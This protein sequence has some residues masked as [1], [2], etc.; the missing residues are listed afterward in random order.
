[1]TLGLVFL[2]IVI[3]SFGIM[4]IVYI[5]LLSKDAR[6]ILKDNH[7]TLE[8]CNNM[9]KSLESVSRDTGAVTVFEHNLSMQEK[10][11][12]EVGERNATIELRK[13]FDRLKASPGDSTYAHNIRNAIY[14]IQD[15]NQLAILRKNKTASATAEN[16]T[17]WL[18]IIVTILTIV[19]FTFI[20]N[21]PGIISA[22]LQALSE[23][24][25]A[26]AGKN[27]SKRI[28][29][30]QSDEFGELAGAFNTMAEKLDEYEHSSLSQILFEKTRIETIINQ[31]KDGIIGFDEKGHVLFMN[32]VAE[33]LFGLKEAEITGQYNADIAIRNDLMRTL[34]QDRE[35]KE[36]KIY[37]DGKE[38]FFIKDPITVN[39]GE[40]L[41]GEV[42]VLRNIT[43]F[44]ELDEA[45]TNFIATVS[46]ELK[47]PMSSI[48]MS[49][50]LLN[51]TR[52]GDMNKEQQEL[53]KS[54]DDDIDRLLKI[55]GELLNMAQVE[56]GNIQLKLQQTTP[57]QVVEVAQLAVATQ[58]AQ[59]NLQLQ[60]F[61]QNN[62]PP[63]MADPEKT[64]WVLI[65]LLTNA[66]KYSHENGTIEITVKRDNNKVLFA[67]ADHGRG[68]EEKYLARV[69][70][71]YFKV[72][73]SI[74]KAGTGLGLAISREFIE[75]QG[76]QIWVS[77]SYGEGSRFVF[78][79]PV[80]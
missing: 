33:N 44:H 78:S 38:S 68:I 54:I 57:E 58:V 4:G 36:L 67:V 37:A 47:T 45:K 49:T 66:I 8:Y 18:T 10:N 40:Q 11:E 24:I 70:D 32:A 13:N 74:E 2:F 64:S 12:T 9:L 41:I 30:K 34:L 62:L 72:P 79:L 56:T 21:F 50:R 77:S 39:N 25:T 7:I 42:I 17:F 31:M 55:T 53:V 35:K 43:P 6:L 23:G 51:D 75:A 5:N 80:V 61:V 48:K 60:L 29:L 16:A 14:R 71:R 15:L 52:V 28:Y 59:R 27:Y 46:H 3:L 19:A 22:P 20:I 63:I 26:I 73:G 1:M 76:G 65:N 69:F